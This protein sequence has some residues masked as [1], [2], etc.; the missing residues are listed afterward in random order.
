MSMRYAV[1]VLCLLLSNGLCP[2]VVA[3]QE[4]ATGVIRA[5]EAVV[6]R[7]EVAGITRSI[8]VREGQEVSEGQVL[9]E[10]RSDI[11]EIG[12][13]LADAGVSRAEA[14][15]AASRVTLE[16]AR[17]TLAR[18]EIAATALTEKDRE[19]VADE[20]RRLEALLRAQEAELAEASVELDL[21]RRQLDETR[22]SSPFDGTVTII[23]IQKGDTVSPLDTP[24]LVLVNLDRMYVELVLPVDEIPNL[25]EGRSVQVQVEAGVLGS[26][27][28]VEGVVS[29]VNPTVDPSSRTF[30]VKI[31]ISDPAR[32]IRPGMRA[33]VRLP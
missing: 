30:L 27:G 2:G 9:V 23:R 24:L 29:Y 26:S 6:V 13:R 33:E 19:D 15:T 11:Q 31:D 20:V 3:A 5:E 17:H 10:M 32:R 1:P 7:S 28:R 16:N 12:V 4:T 14:A 8:E 25:A 22:I 18:V 21:R